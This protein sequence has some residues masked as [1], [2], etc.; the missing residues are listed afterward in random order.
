MAITNSLDGFQKSSWIVTAYLLTYT[1][2]PLVAIGC[3]SLAETGI[4]EFLT[5]VAKLSDIHGRKTLL[6]GC[7]AL[8]VVFSMACGAVHRLRDL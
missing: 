8:F 2:K 7:L 6:V 1:G 3:V 4:V 5:I